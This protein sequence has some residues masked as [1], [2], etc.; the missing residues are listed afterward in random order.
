MSPQEA[1]RLFFP[2]PQE[3]LVGFS[4]GADST[5]LLLALHQAGW[6]V[7]AVHFNHQL[8]GEAALADARFCREFCRVRGIPFRC[9]RLDVKNNRQKGESVE[10]AARRLRLEKWCQL[11]AKKHQLVFLAH[12]AD[13]AAEELFLRILRGASTTGLVGLREL[14]Q[15]NDGTRLARPLLRC[16]KSEL[17]EYLRAEG[18]EKWC[19]DATNFVS[20]CNRNR[21]RNQLL[22]A[23]KKLFGG[24]SGIQATLE[25]LRMDAAYLE[26]EA[27]AALPPRPTI[28]DWRRIPAA[29]FARVLR[30]RF[31]LALPPSRETILRLQKEL[32]EPH[33]GR[34]NLRIPLGAG[35]YL[36]LNHRKGLLME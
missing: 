31:Q 18:V 34:N 8:R 13:D 25:A 2:A 11:T 35:K 9:F 4:G 24:D 3:A 22:P 26:E 7:S 10:S 16:R 20:D 29:L 33:P 1:I 21:I 27:A 14:R 36:I 30:Q 17:E 5:A 23:W 28:D 6:P 19:V 32:A 12:H 15:L